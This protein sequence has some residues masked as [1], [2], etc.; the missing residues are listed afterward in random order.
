MFKFPLIGLYQEKQLINTDGI[1][2]Q[3]WL[4]QVFGNQSISEHIIQ[5]K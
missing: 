1:G 3:D 4:L 2:V 5:L